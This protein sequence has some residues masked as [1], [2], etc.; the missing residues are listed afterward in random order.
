MTNAQ[1]S[2]VITGDAS[3]AKKALKEMAGDV[4]KTEGSFGKLRNVIGDVGKIAG[5]FVIGSALTKLPSLLDGP[6][7]A[8]SSLSESMNAVQVVFGNTSDKITEFGKTASTQIGLSQRAFNEMATP[9]GAMLKNAGFNMDEV[10]D[11]TIDL[12]KRA[13][14]MASVFNTDVGDALTAITAALRGETDPIERYGV[15][16]NAAKVEAEAMA[17]TGKK[18]AA[19]LTDQEKAAAR[20]N[21]IM[22]QTEQVAGDFVNT[23]DGLANKQRIQK[24]R[25][26][27]LSASIGTKLMPIT[28]AFKEVQLSLLS[29]IAERVL[30]VFNRYADIVQTKLGQAWQA[31]QPYVQQAMDFL[32]GTVVP[33]LQENVPVALQRLG[34]FVQS[35]F[36]K[37]KQYYESDIKP[38]LENIRTAAEAVISWISANWPKIS[39]VISPVLA[40]I[41]NRVQLA[42]AVISTALGVVIDL[43]GGDFSGAWTRLKDLVGTIWESIKTS[44]SNALELL[45][46]LAPV[47]QQVGDILMNAI[48]DGLLAVWDQIKIWLPKIPGAMVDALKDLGAEMFK[49][50]K[51]AGEQL[52]QGFKAGA[53]SL[54]DLITPDV[55]IPNLGIRA[56]LGIGRASG[57]PVSAGRPY[58]VGENGPEL[59]MPGRSG[60]IVPNGA[61]GGGGTRQ[62]IILQING[63]ELA[64]VMVDLKDGGAFRGTFA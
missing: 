10:G 17:M 59:F 49:V 43:I 16:V 45:K 13:A 29:L 48:W 63:R 25:A 60:T 32:Q 22:R 62:P 52:W 18:T 23:S 4:E 20:L 30:P 35:E 55:S 26:E 53:K 33:F 46:Q 12:S 9:L 28:V 44:V 50:G 14:D 58:V 42:V 31:A 3:S 41:Q 34:S 39:A 6:V 15:S 2:I 54:A 40:E 24:A 37:F 56:P 21:L 5:G 38:A 19:S 1:L 47:A 51:Q 7:Q 11:K 57:G 36:A 61:L 8:A 27:E 64:R